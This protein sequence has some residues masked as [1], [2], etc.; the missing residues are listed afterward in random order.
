MV[1]I[2]DLGLGWEL[3]GKSTITRCA[4]DLS[5]DGR[6]GGVQLNSQDRYCIDGMRL[7]A[8]SGR[9]GKHLTE[10]KTEIDDG[11][12]YVSFGQIGS[13]PEYFKVWDKNGFE[14]SY[15]LAANARVNISNNITQWSIST[16]KDK[17]NN[18][19]NYKYINDAN[20][21]YLKD[22][23]YVGGSVNFHYQDR[24]DYI[25]RFFKGSVNNPT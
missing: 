8:I 9:D 15:G 20:T 21:L 14:L 16:K 2:R 17:S 11:N 7:I 24:D 10:Y 5:T 23:Y 25:V 12:K 3:K 13:G 22:V 19:I 18:V 4:R 1:R 6:W